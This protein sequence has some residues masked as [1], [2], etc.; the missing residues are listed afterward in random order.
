MAKT[1]LVTGASSGMGREIALRLA[2][3]GYTV[4]GAARRVERMRDLEGSGIRVLGMDITVDG[5]VVAAVER[6][7]AETGRIDVLVNNAGFGLYGSVEDTSMEDVQY[8][9][10]VNFFGVARLTQLVLPHMRAQKAGRIVNIS[11]MGGAIYTPLGAYYHA[12]KHALEAWSDA[13]RFEVA[14]FG[15]E[16]VVV[17]P[18]MIDTEW[19]GVMAE[20]ILAR[21]GSGAYA[22]LARTVVDS[23]TRTYDGGGSSPTV[24]ADA[25]AK[26]VSARRPRTRYAVGRMAKPLIAARRVLSDRAF[27]RL[28]AAAA[29]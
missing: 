15:I 10:D 25:V 6:I 18:G 2:A 24:V 23:T 19:A 12:T 1:A 20:P 16:V 14:P 17:R 7:I 28:L 3:D 22:A 26:A 8:Q 13:L 4:Y 5:Q 11:S 21:S 29:R 27:D 9:F